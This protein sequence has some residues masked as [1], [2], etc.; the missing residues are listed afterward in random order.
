MTAVNWGLNSLFWSVTS[1]FLN[2]QIEHHFFPQ[3]PPFAYMQVQKEVEEYCKK[4]NMPYRA[5][6]F[7]EASDKMFQGLRDTASEQLAA[8]KKNV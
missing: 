7:T 8:R 6:T 3:C 2:L 1:G 4:R 5:L